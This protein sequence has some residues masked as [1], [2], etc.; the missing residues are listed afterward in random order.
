MARLTTA[1]GPWPVVGRNPELEAIGAALDDGD[2]EGVA[3][4]GGAGFGKTRLAAQARHMAVERGLACS[5]VRAT[6][7]AINIPYAA[8]APLFEAFDLSA[9][10]DAGL[11]RAVARA[12]DVRRGDRRM[13]LVVDD[14]QELDDASVTLLDQLVEHNGVFVIFTLRVGEVEAQALVQKWKD[15]RIHRI[16]VG[17]L[18]E[19]DLRTLTELAVGGP[20]EGA[21]AQSFV[22]SSAGNVLLL[23]ELIQGAM[24]AGAL[25]S[26]LGLWRLNDS[27][28][29]SPRLRDLIDQRLAGLS[30]V[31]REALELVALSDPVQLD[32][33]E[34]LVPLE[35]IEQLEHRGLLDVL[36]GEAGPELRLSHPLYG[37]VVRTHLPSIR[38][39]RLSRSLADAAESHGEVHSRDTLRVA[40]WRLDGGGGGRHDTMLTASRTAL[41]TE[42][43]A[44]AIRLSRPVWEKSRSVD[45]AIVLAESLDFLGRCRE[46]EQVLRVATPLATTDRQ[47]TSV[48]ARRASALFRSLGE[49]DEADVVITLASDL[50]TDATCRRELD[51]LRGNLL[52]LAG[53][54]AKAVELDE[55]I[56]QTPGDAAFA[57]ASLDVG[58]GLAFAGRTKEAIDHTSVALAARTDLNDEEQ[59]SA[60]GVYAVAQALAQYHAG[61]LLDAAL[62]GD[63]GYRVSVEKGNV[64]GQAWFSTLMGLIL[65]AQGQPLLSINMF[66]EASTLFGILNH[67]GRRWGLAGVALASAACGDKVTGQRALEELDD[68]PA[69]AVLLQE[70]GAIRGRAWMAM[71][72]GELSNA[73][74]LLWDAVA[75]AEKWGQYATGAEALH[76]LIRMGAVNPA[77]EHL[78]RIGDKV[79]GDFMAAR[80]AFAAAAGAQ[81][82]D[83]AA[84]ASGMF[85]EM[86]ALLFAAEASTLEAQYA[87]DAG[88]RRRASE[89]AAQAQRLLERCEGATLPWLVTRP[90]TAHLSEREREVAMLAAQ[91]LTSK[92]IAERLFVS[93]RTVDNHLQQVYV[94]LGIK[95]RNELPAYFPSSQTRPTT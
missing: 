40:V 46:A 57:Q 76:D 45:A 3:L 52:L 6:K 43:Y 36:G 55:A 77:A 85:E 60:I 25:S 32:L 74:T 1:A 90:G 84:R 31:E 64:D 14:A 56:L 95:R 62:I 79:D 89:A 72:R 75:L 73:R 8:L 35:T 41:R 71:L 42:N 30:T 67:P 83:K 7:S 78:E 58:T 61:H 80:L 39:I 69:T 54:V 29:Q 9:K 27:L 48:A 82:M 22:E 51:A 28:A 5:S 53:D 37:E 33:L 11:F 18:P 26:E 24:E 17:P 94:K 10:L 91:L 12:I 87:D 15:Q 88:L 20:L 63:A 81:D 50:V 4:I 49:A 16:D 38:R 13:V 86:G 70:V 66:R 65:L 59:L 44:L 68:A 93:V 2:C 21:S 47:R 92:Q 23:R 34:Q 19:A